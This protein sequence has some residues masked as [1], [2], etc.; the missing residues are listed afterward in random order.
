MLAGSWNKRRVA[1]TA[2]RPW[3]HVGLLPPAGLVILTLVCMVSEPS[4]LF[5][6]FYK[7]YFRAAEQLW[8]AG[9]GP[10]WSLGEPSVIG[11]VNLPIVA[12]L[13]VPLVPLGE[14]GAAWV[15]LALGLA[16]TG[17]AW[18]LLTRMSRPDVKIGAAL[19]FFFVV[20]GPLINSLRE[21]NTTHF[22]LLLLLLS[23]LLWSTGAEYLAGL[24]LGLCAIVKLPLLLYGVYFALRGRWR[25]VAGGAISIALAALLS[26]AVFGVDINAGWYRNCIEPFLGHV[27][28]AYNVQSVDGFLA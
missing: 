13:F 15:F 11:F 6:D 26:L 2:P 9:P 17:A 7:A 12:W 3:S 19:L 22:I 8:R 24:L 25:V 23:L 5:S 18:A 1:V 28:P 16:A 20:N 21:G 14:E 27:I 4:I 10:T